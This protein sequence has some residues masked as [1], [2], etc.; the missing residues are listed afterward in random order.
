M[1]QSLA[2]CLTAL[3]V[4]VVSYLIGSISHGLLIGKVFFHKDIRDYGSHNLGGTNAGRVLGKPIGILVILLDMLKTLACVYA[5]WA[6]VTYSPLKHFYLFPD[7]PELFQD[8]RPL[9]YWM[10]ALCAGLGHCFPFYLHFKGGKA[11]SSFMGTAACTNWL[12]FV[13]GISYFPILKFKKMVSL[14][15]LITGGLET[16]AAWIVFAVCA[17]TH[18]P[19]YFFSWTFALKDNALVTGFWYAIAMSCLYAVLVIR[20][21]SNMMRI[22]AGVENKI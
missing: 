21:R 12:G 1:N 7:A 8:L 18:F 20:H 22:K 10:A 19:L 11:V 6:I 5:T 15:S 16:I 2:N 4:A 17:A 14:A 9:Y 3:I 13:V